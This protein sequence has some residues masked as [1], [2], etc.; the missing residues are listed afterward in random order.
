MSPAEYIADYH[1][2]LE[3][4][5]NGQCDWLFCSGK[6]RQNFASSVTLYPCKRS[7]QNHLVT[8]LNNLTGHFVK[9]KIKCDSRTVS[10]RCQSWCLSIVLRTAQV[11]NLGLVK[12]FKVKCAPRFLPKSKFFSLKLSFRHLFTI[13]PWE[14][15]LWL[16][17]SFLQQF[18]FCQIPL[19]TTSSN[20]CD[21]L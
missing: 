18:F 9:G 19:L 4:N 13:A 11:P 16:L 1:Y 6:D 8:F 7:R 5:I 10:R 17:F 3:F 15:T 2:A 14:F 12:I 20:S 21:L